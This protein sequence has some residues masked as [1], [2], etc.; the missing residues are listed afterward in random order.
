MFCHS[1]C[2]SSSDTKGHVCYCHHFASAVCPFLSGL[3]FH[4]LMVFS[5]TT[6]TYEAKLYMNDVCDVPH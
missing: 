2:I 4:I 3:T 1:Q 6:E 5:E